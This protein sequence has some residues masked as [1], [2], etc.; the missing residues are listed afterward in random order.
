[1]KT[2]AS[3]Q[4][5][6][7]LIE[8]FAIDV[9]EDELAHFVRF[10]SRYLD[11]EGQDALVGA[12][13][14]EFATKAGSAKT[15]IARVAKRLYR[16]RHRPLSLEEV[17]PVEATRNAFDM[18]QLIPKFLKQL[19]AKSELEKMYVFDQLFVEG[20]SALDVS[21]QLGVKKHKIYDLRDSLQNEFRQFLERQPS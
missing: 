19:H 21:R 10:N 16:E 4:I 8:R 20:R 13:F 14:V 11:D 7:M 1:M 5:A 12:L 2:E 3:R 17:G 15:V 18:T 6:K 9:T